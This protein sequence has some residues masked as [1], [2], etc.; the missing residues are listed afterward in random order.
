M[1][2]KNKPRVPEHSVIEL[3]G[4]RLHPAGMAVVNAP[5]WMRRFASRG[6]VAYISP[7]RS[8]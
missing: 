1:N 2:E 7:S 4:L 6:R 8:C 3:E 5:F